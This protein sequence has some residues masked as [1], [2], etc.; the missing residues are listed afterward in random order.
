MLRL[1]SPSESRPAPLTLVGSDQLAARRR[2]GAVTARKLHPAFEVTQK[3]LP[4]TTTAV[5]ATR[6]TFML[7]VR[8]AWP[9][10]RKRYSPAQ[11]SLPCHLPYRLR[12]RPT[13][14]SL[15]WA[16][17]GRSAASLLPATT[18]LASSRG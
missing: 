7:S 5:S 14:F 12:N 1:F 16:F 13:V 11:P 8:Q 9:G 15:Q 18:H 4:H 3:K 2:N 6:K 17:A 10:F